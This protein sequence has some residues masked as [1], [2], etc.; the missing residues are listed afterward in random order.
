MDHSQMS[1]K[2]KQNSKEIQINLG[3]GE[4]I[5]PGFINVDVNYYKHI[6]FVSDVKDLHFFNDNY[7]DLLYSS[8]TLEYFDRLQ[9]NEALTEWNRVLKRGGILRISVPDFKS[10]VEVYT[11]YENWII[12]E[13]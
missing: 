4:K 1:V 8:H 12:R 11:K 2:I 9:V 13:F 5:I 7:A 6:D 10:I 3:C